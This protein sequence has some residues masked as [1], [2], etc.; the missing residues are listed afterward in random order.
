[1]TL[2][3]PGSRRQAAD[4][5][6]LA[7]VHEAERL[8]D[9]VS[10]TREELRD[11]AR[12][13]LGV[14][15]DDS[16]APPLREALQ[17]YGVT[18]YPLTILGVL[19]VVDQ[20]QVYGFDV[21]RPEISRALG[22]GLGTIGALTALQFL[23][24]AVAPLVMAA[25][26]QRRPRR[27]LVCIL[28]AGG[29]AI[30]TVYTGFIT[31]LWGL[32]IV[33]VL[34][35]LSSGSVAALHQPLLIDSYPPQARVRALSYY[36]AIGRFGNV[37]APL[38]VALL[39]GALGFTWRGVFLVFGLA[40]IA[41]LPFTF[42]LR[43][44]GFG[45]YDTEQLRAAVHEHHGEGSQLGEDEVSLGFFEIVRR[46]LLIPTIRRLLVAFTVFGLLLIPYNTVLS[47]YLE[48][49]L[50]FGPGQRGLFFAGTAASGV[51][52][53]A[54]FGKLGEQMFRKDPGRVVEVAGILL[55]IG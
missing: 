1:M 22:I 19:F 49:N 20:F 44:P 35:G 26:V 18:V 55:A 6:H 39:A 31:S 47:F 24:I 13:T 50:G 43:D 41:I 51:L 36:G 52:A 5:S 27:A 15:G 25:Y 3:P 34:D 48:E 4:A 23:A 16:K 14:T 9:E 33:L 40:C 8:V 21:L 2:A 45:R 46:L 32:A 17:P 29:W 37:L 38:G 7:K 54:I 12:R 30:A 10:E 11:A 28:T 53:L 42:W